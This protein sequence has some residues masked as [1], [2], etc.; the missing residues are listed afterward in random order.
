MLIIKLTWMVVRDTEYTLK[1]KLQRSCFIMKKNLSTAREKIQ[2]AY[3]LIY[4]CK[5][6]WADINMW[7][8]TNQVVSMIPWDR[9]LYIFNFF[10]VTHWCLYE[11]LMWTFGIDKFCYHLERHIIFWRTLHSCWIFLMTVLLY[12]ACL[13]LHLLH[14]FMIG[15]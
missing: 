7:K 2:N 1:S 8:K 4:V 13:M 10:P 12:L 9:V 15:F 14:I 3:M 6:L 11:R 5:Y